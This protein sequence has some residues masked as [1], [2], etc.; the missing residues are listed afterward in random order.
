[1]SVQTENKDIVEKLTQQ[2]RD[3]E[4]QHTLKESALRSQLEKEIRRCRD[5]NK[6]LGLELSNKKDHC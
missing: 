6:K 2:I 1:M 5:Q 4:R 3:M